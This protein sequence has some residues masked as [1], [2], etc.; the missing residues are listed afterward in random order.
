ME[1]VNSQ[2]SQQTRDTDPML[3]ECSADVK[4]GGPKLIGTLSHVC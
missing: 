2:V 4:D 3:F 1:R